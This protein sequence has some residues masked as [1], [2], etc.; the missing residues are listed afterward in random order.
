MLRAALKNLMAVVAVCFCLAFANAAQ[1]LN[2][3]PTQTSSF[4]P[5]SERVET[6]HASTILLADKTALVPGQTI[7]LALDQVLD[8][9]WHVYWK[10]PGATGLALNLTWTLPAG[11]S[12]GE[13]I[14][15]T[16]ERI[17]VGDFA[18]YGHHGAPVFLIPLR[19][20]DDITLGETVDIR[21]EAT[22]LICEEVCVPEDAVFSL[23][24]PVASQAEIYRP[25]AEKVSEALLHAPTTFQGTAQ[26]QDNDRE[27]ILN[28]EV[29]KTISRL[30]K[31]L[32][33]FPDIAGLSDPSAPQAVTIKGGVATLKIMPGYEFSRGAFETIR[34]VI[35]VQKGEKRGVEI[36]APVEVIAAPLAYEGAIDDPSSANLVLLFAA[37]FIGGALL[38]LMPC[39]FPIVFIKAATFIK[40]ARS[41]RA[42]LRFHGVLYAAGVIATFAVLGGAL[43]IL[44]AGGAEIG[45]GFHLQSPFVVALSAYVLFLVGL[46]L[47]GLFEIGETAQRLG[48]AVEVPAGVG[49]YGDKLA[50]FL[51]G[52][53]AVVVAAPCIG[54]FLSAPVG[55]AVMVSPPVGLAIF[56]VMGAGLALPYVVLAFAPG[57]GALLPKPGAWMAVFK[58]GL[59]FPVFAGAAFF[60]WVLAQQT[61][62]AGLAAALGGAVALAFA[63]WAFELSKQEGA[64]ALLLRGLCAIAILAATG[65]ALSLKP[66]V[67]PS[68]SAHESAASDGSFQHGALSAVAYDP[69]LLEAKRAEGT[70]V[71]VDF[72]AAWCVTCQFN[73]RTVLS[74]EDLAERFD[75]AGVTVMVGDWTLR[76]PIITAALEEFNANGV[77]LYVY[78]DHKGAAKP[79]P[80]PLTK[81]AILAAIGR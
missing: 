80:L 61:G 34:G 13:I 38:N 8:K 49:A 32:F 20:A 12:A 64:G 71:F 81:R 58:Q 21:L 68:I 42:A 25:G 72:T 44:R 59:S 11:V 52:V 1:A 55:A 79:F 67:A 66:A 14:Y 16:P 2:N 19:V 26:F 43:L 54:P 35:G 70:P 46:N 6:D 63:A 50:S 65:A 51:T 37:A 45:W 23:S 47:A 29:D 15:P 76:D 77:P 28:I 56:L 40:S 5:R 60:L 57:L 75:K 39:V 7:T 4:E 31:E 10:N 22:W 62:P 3:P 73:K 9:G 33:F 48:G 17:M 74:N 69:A 36:N 18:N 27:L 24:L 41:E 53:L 30:G 78:Y